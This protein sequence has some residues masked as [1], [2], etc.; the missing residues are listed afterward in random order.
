MD[1]KVFAGKNAAVSTIEV[2][3]EIPP[4]LYENLLALDNVLGVSLLDQRNAK[5]V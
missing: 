3:G 4:D 1:N 2:A 5:S